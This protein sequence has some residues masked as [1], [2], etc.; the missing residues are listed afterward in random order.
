MLAGSAICAT[1]AACGDRQNTLV[2]E[3]RLDYYHD[4]TGEA[5]CP[6][7]VP[8]E[9]CLPMDP[10]QRQSLWFDIQN[11]IKWYTQECADI[12]YAAMDFVNTGDMRTWND[13]S[14]PWTAFWSKANAQRGQRVAIR[15]DRMSW[16]SLRLRDMMHEGTHSFY[17]DGQSVEDAASWVEYNCLN[18]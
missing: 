12:G 17:Q 10:G 1:L 7:Y 14:S 5:E 2:T 6:D 4:D 15:R 11:G 3:P 18:N 13:P 16:Q 8:E 9:E